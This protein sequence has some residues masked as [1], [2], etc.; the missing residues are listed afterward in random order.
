MLG[1]AHKTTNRGT[2]GSW[3][4]FPE[5]DTAANSS[6]FYCLCTAE[7]RWHG[8]RTALVCATSRCHRFVIPTAL[9]SCP[10]PITY[11]CEQL[12]LHYHDYICI[13][14]EWWCQ[15][16]CLSR[17]DQGYRLFIHTLILLQRRFLIPFHRCL[18]RVTRILWP[19]NQG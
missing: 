14:Q 13:Y 7:N 6:S 2:V 15:V 18:P 19:Y 16:L 17:R 8:S 1:S 5:K 10:S 9:H 4:V 12:H 3:T 11:P